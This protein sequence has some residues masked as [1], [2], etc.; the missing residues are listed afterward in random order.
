[1][2]RQLIRP[3]LFLL[4]PEAAHELVAFMLRQTMHI[5]GMPWLMRNVYSGKGHDHPRDLFGLHFPSPIGLAAGFDKKGNLYPAM[6]QF[7][8]GFIE[9]G[10]VT[11][12]PQAGNPRP[13]LFRLPSQKAMINR[14][15]FNNE[16]VMA[17]VRRISRQKRPE[18]ISGHP[19][20]LGGNI[21]RNTLT[22]AS[23][24]IGDYVRC[25]TSLAPWVDYI[26]INVSCPNVSGLNNLQQKDELQQ[27]LG[28]IQHENQLRPRPL[29]LFLKI[30]PDLSETQL[31]QIIHLA[32][33]HDIK[34][35]VATNTSALREGLDIP[36]KRID[37]LGSGG[38]SGKPLSAKSTRTIA[39]IHKKSQGRMPVIASGGIMSSQDA[40]EK[41][42]AGACL[43]QLYTGFIYEGPSMV[44]KIMRSLG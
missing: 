39:Y 41:L 15:G 8:F 21:G 3:L 26:T 19:I 32:F 11:P 44:K 7:G 34:A 16:G 13:R 35:L 23:D 27:L 24:T 33:D 37:R 12:R 28:A 2:Y 6:G 5:P 43:V 4:P 30:S 10:T 38:L 9:I 1:M 20:I 22:S 40:L 18:H 36:Q 29:P 42:N 31:D 14:M 17:M 25:F